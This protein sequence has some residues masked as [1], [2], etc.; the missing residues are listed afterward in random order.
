MEFVGRKS[1]LAFLEDCY[2]DHRAQLVILYGRR[3]VGKT[4]LLRRFCTGRPHVF[5]ASN[6]APAQ[7][8]LA[9]FS[10]QMFAAGAPAGRYLSSYAS[11]EDAL[12][13]IPELP[14]EGRRLVVIDEFPYLVKSDPSLPS[15]L[16]NAWDACLKDR[17]VMIVLCGS[18]MSFME[19]ELL[20]EKNP[21]YGRA[22]GILKLEPMPYRDTARFFPGYSPEEHVLAYAVLGGTPHYLAQFDPDAGLEDNIKRTILRRG[23]ALYNEVEF[24][25]RQELRETA[26]YNSIVQ[27]VALGATQ[28]N[29]IA[30]K[31]MIPAQ[32]A[33]V[34]IRNL[35]EMGVLKREFPVGAGLQE[36]AKAQRGLYRVADNFFRFWYAYVF[37]NQSALEMLDV[38]GV[39]EHGVEPSLNEFAAVPFEDICRAWMFER[40]RAGDLPVY[41]TDIGRWWR[42]GD[43]IDVLGIDKRGGQAVAGECKFRNAPVDMRVLHAL[44]K[45]VEGLPLEVEQLLLFSKNG[46]DDAVVERASHDERLRLVG[47]EELEG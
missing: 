10:Q 5:S 35:I 44:E 28:L 9:S 34:Y 1:E 42:G 7:S 3:R 14:F 11:W 39:W 6:E 20:A 37:S 38:D 47:L 22:T 43:E 18:A 17:D 25:M 29:E 31:T 23:S 30:Q 26:V 15:V 36:R 19:H 16:Q 45:K 32:K 41:C 12:A 8:Q 24:L 2:A 27:A 21:L 4:E 46:F 13:D 33:S 40:N